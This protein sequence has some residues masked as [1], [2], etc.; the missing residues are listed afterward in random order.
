MKVMTI[1]CHDVYN[2]GASLQA[3]AL[4]KYLKDIG[5]DVEIIDYKPDYLSRH[6]RLTGVSP[7]FNK[8]VLRLA[9]LAA[10]FP[11]RLMARYGRRKKAYDSFTRDFL[12]TTKRRYASNED[13]KDNLPEADVYIAGSDQIWNTAFRNGRDPSF[14]LDFV[15]QD[16]IK[17]S[18]AASFATEDVAEEYKEKITGWLKEFDF[19]SVRESSGVSI[20]EN[21]GILGSVQVM[22]PVFLLEAK[23]WE[24]LASD[25]P[26]KEKYILVYDFDKNTEVEGLAKKIA[27][28]KNLKIYSVLPSAYAHKCFAKYG[29]RTFVSLVKNAEFVISNSFHATAFSLIFRKEFVVF[30]R[31]EKINTRMKDL[32]SLA[33]LEHRIMSCADDSIGG[34]IDYEAPVKALDVGINKSKEYLDKVLNG[35]KKDD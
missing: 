10:K 13:L 8:P 2:A 15:P 34:T 26:K 18:F 25:I 6:H 21:L 22:D 31:H 7:R 35:V 12:P 14:Y 27:A 28:E 23:T 16:K 20:I 33:G 11:K 17:A 29:P 9:Y 24:A 3:Y 5:N 4:A 32:L 30:N 1:T 19:I